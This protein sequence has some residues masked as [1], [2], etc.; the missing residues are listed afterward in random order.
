MGPYPEGTDPE[1][2]TTDVSH[3]QVD[4][5]SRKTGTGQTAG[6]H[7]GVRSSTPEIPSL[8]GIRALAVAVVFLGH[9]LPPPFPG[10]LGVTV[11]F[12]LSGYLITTLLRIEYQQSGNISLR[13]FYL[14]RVLRIFPPFY[15]VL[16]GATL[17][18]A[19]GQL[20]ATRLTGV[21]LLSEATYWLNY[22]ILAFDW[23]PGDPFGG[24][25]GTGVYWSLAVEEHFYLLFPLL[26]LL[27]LRHV[28]TR[29]RQAVVLLAVCGLILAWRC[30]LIYVLHSSGNRTYMAT[31]TRMDSL[32]FGCALAI[33]A[34][35]VLDKLRWTEDAWE[36]LLV[37]LGI[38]GILIGLAISDQG[39]HETIRYT[40]QGLCLAPLFVVAVRYPNWWLI[41]PLNWRW[42]AWL[43]LCSYSMYLLHET[44]LSAVETH[45]HAGVIV[46][47]VVS[48]VTTVALAAVIREAV[49]KPLQAWRRRLSR[50][51]L[52]R[53]TQQPSAT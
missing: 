12:F 21:T 38:A 35:P 14:R 43:G 19:I 3:R 2:G 48:A 15:I 31:D 5:L 4:G 29:R 18:A 49:E 17:L 27:L 13:A 24:A 51:H 8:N 37:P 34:N 25:P 9:L 46:V 52:D 45:V 22:R 28:A 26:Y 39:F 1:S 41:K 20:G 30:V 33:G 7:P 47:G 44:V 32:L 23:F 36:L 16:L 10:Q 53:A 6:A 11:F 42:V 50:A 40:I